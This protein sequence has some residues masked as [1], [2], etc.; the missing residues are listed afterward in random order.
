MSK[1]VRLQALGRLAHSR[2]PD[3][4]A[5]LKAELEAAVSVLNQPRS[6]FALSQALDVLEVIGFRFSEEVAAVAFDFLTRIKNGP[7]HIFSSSAEDDGLSNA[8][9]L[10]YL[11]TKAIDVA[12]RLRYLQ[13][14]AIV[15]LLLRESADVKEGVRHK[16]RSGLDSVV[17]YEAFVFFGDRENQ[18]P[19]IGPQPQAQVLDV[20]ERMADPEIVFF[21]DQVRG[22]AEKILSPTVNGARWRSDSVQLSFAALPGI[23]EVKAIRERAISL[24]I[25]LSALAPTSEKRISVIG[26]LVAASRHE[27]RA[28][29]SPNVDEMIRTDTLRILSF[30]EKEATS[31]KSF[32]VLQALEARAYRIFRNSSDTD[33][34]AAAKRVEQVIATNSEYQI[35]RTLIG[36]EGVFEPWDKSS[37][38]AKGFRKTE[39]LRKK[40][41][42]EY[43]GEVDQNSREV[44]K[45]RIL[46][47]A[48]TDSSDL[49]T[50][51]VFYQFLRDL[52][53]R[54]PALALELV[55]SEEAQIDKFLI[56]LLAGL[57]NGDHRPEL[58]ALI[59]QWF[60]GPQLV[61]RYL[62]PLVKMFLST[63]SID[64]PLLERLREKATEASDVASLRQVASVAIAR[65]DKKSSALRAIF[66]KSIEAMT[67]V[68]DAG[69]VY[70]AWYRPELK[71]LLGSLNDAEVDCVL[72]NL[73]LLP[74]LDF[75]AEEVL[76]AVSEKSP[77]RV[78]TYLLDRLR[79]SLRDHAS[80]KPEE[81]EAIPFDFHKLQTTLSAIPEQAVR[82]TLDLY[83]ESPNEFRFGGA[84][85][86]QRIFSDYPK[87]FESELLTLV[88]TRIPENFDFVL[89]VLRNYEGQPFL[90]NL[91]RE[92]VD[93]AGGDNT[94][95]DDVTSALLTTGVVSG[96]FGFAEAY[97]QKRVEVSEW[98]HDP[99]ESVR[100]FAE[101]VIA[102]L[103]KARDTE[104]ARAE[105]SVM[106]R[107]HRYKED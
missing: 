106:L 70:D 10:D 39:E 32:P 86:L 97:E 98:L 82:K 96:E 16:A 48:K 45:A 11:A 71:E 54:V 66:L 69:W 3:A 83:R 104:K 57:W 58:Q 91:L 1:D 61:N 81:F 67:S 41:A 72:D 43:V 29:R 33:V 19:G 88:R 62:F 100:E 20:L 30:F 44:W 105:E 107:K 51:P 37:D 60:T 18:Q 15:M 38:E 99:R 50:F 8:W 27:E 34:T 12:L 6:G 95:E 56:P 78:L 89:D 42:L 13:T 68:H 7:N 21:F 49:A 40:R 31:E 25:H 85:L 103:A 53:G 28:P 87:P 79:I 46:E 47:F 74:K 14:K 9:Y 102:K 26:S 23:P 94:I 101:S 76:S 52:A 64:L 55:S 65:F 92:I 2:S 77:V 17:A 36:F 35:Y 63:E 59:E 80:D 5:A 75:H 84:S 4:E 22:L 93:A 73:A 24:L 90:H